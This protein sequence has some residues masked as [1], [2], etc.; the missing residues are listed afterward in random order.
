MQVVISVFR[1]SSTLLCATNFYMARNKT[2]SFLLSL[3]VGQALATS[4]NK[5]TILFSLSLLGVGG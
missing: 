4:Q 3:I 5:V 1:L 2:F